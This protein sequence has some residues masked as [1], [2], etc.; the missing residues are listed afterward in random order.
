MAGEILMIILMTGLDY[1]KAELKVREKFAFTKE[2]KRKFLKEFTDK[3]NITGCV[4]L[5][6]CNRTELYISIEEDKKNNLTKMLCDFLNIEYKEYK[7]YFVERKNETALVHLFKVSAGMDSLILGDDQI[8]TQVREDLEISRGVNCTD[9]YIETCFNIAIKTGKQIKTK[10]I[11]R[12][13][14]ISNAPYK[15]VEKLKLNTNLKSKNVL[16]IGN[17]HMGRTTAE[18]LIK[19]KANVTITLREYKSSGNII[20]KGASFISYKH[21][22]LILNSIDIVI[23]A[24]TSP[25]YTLKYNDLA[26]LDKPPKIIIDLAV[27]RD[28]EPSIKNINGISIFT[29]DDIEKRD[30]SIIPED[31]MKIIY[32]IINDSLNKYKKWL[33]YKEDTN[34]GLCNRHWAWR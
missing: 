29:I 33:C 6:T 15:A 3:N 21:R 20:P 30:S 16:V 10:V 19:E 14:K 26:L 13:P 5:S 34:D 22:Q 28:I 23:S 9:S 31:K 1:K 2:Q 24:T 18:L 4:L 27:P 7:E 32:G 25:H 8:I 12:D 17:G 11:I